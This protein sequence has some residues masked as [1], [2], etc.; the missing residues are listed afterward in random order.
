MLILQIK[1]FYVNYVFI[2]RICFSDILIGKVIIFRILSMH[3]SLLLQTL[4]VFKYNILF[5]LHQRKCINV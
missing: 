4:N 5:L 3:L 2:Y 1:I